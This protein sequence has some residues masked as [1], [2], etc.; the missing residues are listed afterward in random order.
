MLAW[1]I[2]DR[3]GAKRNADYIQMHRELAKEFH[4]QLH[5]VMDTEVTDLLAQNR[6]NYADFC[7]VRTIQPQLSKQL[8]EQGIVVFNSAFVSEICNDKGKTIQY[9]KSHTEVPV[10]PTKC[11]ARKQ[12]SEELLLQHKASVIKAVDGHGGR[13][14]FLTSEPY[15]RIV[16]G[17]G[18]SNFILQPLIQGAGKDIRVYVIGNRIMGAVERIAKSGFKSNFSLGGEI[19]PY[20]LKEN[21]RNMVNTICDI[22]SFGMVGI[23]F[24]IDEAGNFLFNEIEDVVGARM[25]YQ[26]Y[27]Q[28]NL[29]REYFSFVM[30][31]VAISLDNV[32]NKDDCLHIL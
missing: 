13:Q 1:L 19:F 11:F 10:I 6:E 15:E 14:V 23:D 30:K 9:V 21:E 26:C 5:L 16:R 27:P 12:L 2:Y 29:L 7:F 25:Y 24:I 22:F 28:I 17:I 31:R 20:E 18:K 4:I 3:E 32:Y 8:E